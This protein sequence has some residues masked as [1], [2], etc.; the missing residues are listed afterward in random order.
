MF[1]QCQFHGENFHYCSDR[2]TRSTNVGSVTNC[3]KNT[4][5]IHN[6]VYI[7]KRTFSCR[8]RDRIK[9]SKKHVQRDQDFRQTSCWIIIA[10]THFFSIIKKKQFLIPSFGSKNDYI[11]GS[12]RGLDNHILLWKFRIHIQTKWTLEE[13]TPNERTRCAIHTPTLLLRF[14]TPI[15][16]DWA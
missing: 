4:S 7:G 5:H 11:S 12:A 3:E 6:Y 16:F 15:V 8:R 9:R 13:T 1:T 2:F 10:F 14:D